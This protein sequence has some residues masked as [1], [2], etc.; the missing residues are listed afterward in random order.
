MAAADVL[1]LVQLRIVV[2]RVRS[3]I[4]VFVSHSNIEINF[5]IVPQLIYK[6]HT[7]LL[8]VTILFRDCL[9]VSHIRSNDC[10]IYKYNHPSIGMD[11]LDFY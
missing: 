5:I 11:S 8:N 7:D 4:R 10:F 9:F 1:P 3:Y 6:T 2:G